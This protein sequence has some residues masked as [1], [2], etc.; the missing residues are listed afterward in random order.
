MITIYRPLQGHNAIMNAQELIT[1]KDSGIWQDNI[2]LIEMTSAGPALRIPPDLSA[3]TYSHDPSVADAD[4]HCLPEDWPILQ[5]GFVKNPQA[6]FM[7]VQTLRLTG[8]QDTASALCQE[9]MAYGML[10]SGGEFHAWLRTHHAKAP[11]RTVHPLTLFDSHPAYHHLRLNR[12]ARANMINMALRMELVERLALIHHIGDDK[13]VLLTGNGRWFCAGGDTAEF[14]KAPSPLQAHL[15]RLQVPLPAMMDGI[16]HRLH[17]HLH[18]AVIGAGLELAAYAGRVT[19]HPST[20]F[21]LPETAMGLLPGCGGTVSIARRIGRQRLALICV[22][23]LELTATEALDWGLIDEIC[24]AP[25]DF[26][27]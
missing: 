9:S 4:I 5:A 26:R 16:G 1:L 7:L 22:A 23:G 10:Q 13:P 8:G 17:V 18:G 21:R 25:P 15:T 11:E 27:P 3:I 14:G 24:D 12:P 2:A 6:A 20:T 19:A